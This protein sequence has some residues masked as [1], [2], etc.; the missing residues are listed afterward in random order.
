MFIFIYLYTYVYIYIYIY[1]YIRQPLCGATMAL[2][3]KSGPRLCADYAPICDDVFGPWGP[4]DP[5]V[6]WCGLATYPMGS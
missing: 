3:C 2:D 4:W 1:I 5:K 6:P